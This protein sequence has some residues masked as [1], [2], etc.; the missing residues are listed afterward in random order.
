[1][2][3]RRPGCSRSS[4][5]LARF[6]SPQRPKSWG[7]APPTLVPVV[8]DPNPRG[9]VP[10]GRDVELA[11]QPAAHQSYESFGKQNRNSITI[12]SEKSNARIIG[13][14]TKPHLFPM[15]QS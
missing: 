3:R 2:L 11:G 13:L 9:R 4:C 5:G 15:L 7:G 14:L 1:M 8:L 10:R 12:G 6:V